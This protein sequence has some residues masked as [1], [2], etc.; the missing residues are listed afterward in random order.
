MFC[1]RKF[2]AFDFEVIAIDGHNYEEIDQA[3]QAV[4]K[5]N[6]KPYAIVMKTFKGHGVSFLE[7]KDGWHGK[8]LKKDELEP[9]SPVRL[10][11][12]KLDWDMKP[13]LLVEQENSCESVSKNFIRL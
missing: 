1:I 7:N 5:P 4:Q 11:K 12:S 13:P 6:G 9:K 10:V 2:K 8:A 3:L